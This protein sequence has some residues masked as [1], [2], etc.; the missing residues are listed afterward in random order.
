MSIF[1]MALLAIFKSIM[2][3]VCF[4]RQA[5]KHLISYVRILLS[6]LGVL[7]S[8]LIIDGFL[9]IK[10]LSL[11]LRIL[12]KGFWFYFSHSKM[13]ESLCFR[14]WLCSGL[15]SKST[16]FFYSSIFDYKKAEL[17]IIKAKLIT[18]IIKRFLIRDGRVL[19]WGKGRQVQL[20]SSQ[21]YLQVSIH[22]QGYQVGRSHWY[23]LGIAFFH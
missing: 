1:F 23:I 16:S 17:I 8:C 7:R 11:F 20:S 19:K 9:L 15:N 3:L 14:V 10:E 6:V 21:I 5:M 2:W 22:F 13:R 4:C 12:M 18:L